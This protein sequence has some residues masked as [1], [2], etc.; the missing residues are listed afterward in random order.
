MLPS[1]ILRRPAIAAAAF[2]AFDLMPAHF[3]AM[4]QADAAAAIADIFAMPIDDA[5]SNKRRALTPF[6]RFLS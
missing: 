2:S 1:L 4:R 3:F 5:I 6:R